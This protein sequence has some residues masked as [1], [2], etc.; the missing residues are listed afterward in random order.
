VREAGEETGVRVSRV[1]AFGITSDVMPDVGRHYVT[2]V[3]WWVRAAGA[4][5]FAGPQSE[6]LSP[7]RHP[8]RRTAWRLCHIGSLCGC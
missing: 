1:E 2:I 5:H 3:S 4:R 8:D 6:H 7:L